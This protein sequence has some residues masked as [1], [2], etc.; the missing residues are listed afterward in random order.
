[1]REVFESSAIYNRVDKLR[2]EKNWTIYELAKKAN[3]S[4]N[5]LYRWR[6]KKS[7]PTLYLLENL[8]EAFGVSLLYL[9]FDIE[10]VDYLTVEHRI[11]L[12]KWNRLSVS[13]KNTDL[14]VINSYI[15]D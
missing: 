1:M 7:S 14:T 2:L 11:I 5:S 10:K 4:V 13:Q 3:I 15:A 6:D 8:A 9:L 12:D